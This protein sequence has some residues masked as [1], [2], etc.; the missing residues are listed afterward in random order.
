VGE[1][2]LEMLVRFSL[3][4]VPMSLTPQTSDPVPTATARVA[5]A[6][7]PQGHVYMQMRDTCGAF[8][9]E[10]AFAPLCSPRGQPGMAPAC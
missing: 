10:D 8:Y 2:E 5:K 1:A 3:M 9:T 7:F 4:E 6:A